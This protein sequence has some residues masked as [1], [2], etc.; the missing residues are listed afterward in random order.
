MSA[1]QCHN[2]ILFLNHKLSYSYS[3]MHPV[4][5]RSSVSFSL[6]FELQ[7]KHE[8]SHLNSSFRHLKKISLLRFIHIVW[9]NLFLNATVFLSHEV[10]CVEVYV[11]VQ[12]M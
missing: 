2:V 7:F 10:G 11:Y 8:F 3:I 9:C 6:E 1:S 12:M 5:F 4:C